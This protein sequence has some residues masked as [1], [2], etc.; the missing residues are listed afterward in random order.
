M[1]TLTTSELIAWISTAADSL[2]EHAAE[3]TDLDAAIGDAD[4]GTNMKRGMRAA[5][6]AVA[7]AEFET[8]AALA[9]KVGMSLVSAVGGASGPLYGTFFL[10]FAQGAGDAADLDAEALAAALDAAAAGVAQRGKAEVGEKTMLDAL[11]PAADA[12]KE[13]AAEGAD[14]TAMLTAAV[15]AAREGRDAV[16]DSVATKGRASYVGERAKG[17]IDPGSQSA[18]LLLE[19]LQAAVGAA[20]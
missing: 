11:R 13:A 5:A 16:I 6:D 4:H 9:K 15:A 7:D 20:A 3:L 10:R 18:V 1:S 8:P 12:A 14:I 19:A 2:A 17:H